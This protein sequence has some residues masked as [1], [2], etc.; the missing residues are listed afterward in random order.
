MKNASSVFP[1][2]TLSV[3][4]NRF[5][6]G[7][8]CCE[9][10][11][12]KATTPQFTRE[13]IDCVENSFGFRAF[14]LLGINSFSKSLV[15]E[16]KTVLDM[17]KIALEKHAA[18]DVVL[19]HHVEIVRPGEQSRFTNQA[20]EDL[21]HKESLLRARKLILA[22]YPSVRVWMVYGRLVEDE[23]RIE[24]SDILPDMREKIRMYTPYRYKGIYSCENA[25]LICPDYRFRREGRA[26]MRYSL[27]YD[28]FAFIGIPGASKRLIE[29]SET[30]WKEIKRVIKNGCKRL[31]VMHHSDC[32]A[33][34]GIGAFGGDAIAEEQYH[35]EQMNIL[36][37]M[38][39]EHCKHNHCQ[40]VEVIKIYERFIDDN[41]RIEFVRFD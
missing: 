14:D 41:E 20:E 30:A 3:V 15:Q 4:P 28:R 13:E 40:T 26:C 39:S 7:S 34:N 37:H 38:I 18:E 35:R 31:V 8:H 33:Y 23:N 22:Q 2:I 32:G 17:L 24:F 1:G 6:Q 10:I 9:A 12:L 27:L 25:L 16:S 29:G 19:F 5:F 21:Y 36:Q 11:V